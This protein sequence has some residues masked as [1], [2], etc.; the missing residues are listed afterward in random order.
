MLAQWPLVMTDRLTSQLLVN[1]LVRRT[2]GEGGFATVLRKGEAI[3]GAIIVQLTDRGENQ[4]LFERVTALS[5]E[6]QLVPC[7]PPINS[8]GAEITQY[9]DKRLRVDPDIWIVELDIPQAQRLAAE[10]LCAG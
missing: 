2:Q 8:Q 9:L 10:T 1:F 3:S 6:A 4:G 5:G 7:G